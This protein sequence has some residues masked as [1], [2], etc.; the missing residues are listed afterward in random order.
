M[1]SENRP[2]LAAIL[3]LIGGILMVLSGAVFSMFGFTGFGMMGGYRG[4]MGGFGFPFGSMVG[5]SLIGLMSGVLVIIAA[6]ML[7]TRPS[8]HTIWG[9]I[10]LVFSIIS[11]L[12]M[13]GF[14]VGAILGIIGGAFAL[15]W[16]PSIKV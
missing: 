12:G 7:D 6:V 16:R 14:F 11:F 1:S 3:S 8:E 9:I 5:L 13:G 10:V 15:S 2:T 4:M